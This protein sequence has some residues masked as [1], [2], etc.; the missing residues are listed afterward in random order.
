[1]VRARGVAGDTS[2]HRCNV[3]RHRRLSARRAPALAVVP[4]GITEARGA[5][6]MVVEAAER[7]ER[8]PIVAEGQLLKTA[9]ARAREGITQVLPPRR[10]RRRRRRRQRRLREHP[11]ILRVSMVGHQVTIRDLQRPLLVHLHMHGLECL[12][13]RRHLLSLR[14]LPLPRRTPRCAHRCQLPLLLLRR[15]HRLLSLLPELLYPCQPRC[16]S[17]NLLLWADMTA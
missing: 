7:D 15:P 8:A 9:R 14:C 6:L 13:L 5:E 10:R 1:M 12:Q 16:C 3:L 17:S 2:L 4:P 11:Q